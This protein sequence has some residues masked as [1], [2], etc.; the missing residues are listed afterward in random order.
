MAAVKVPA[1][2]HALGPASMIGL[3]LEELTSISSICST[4]TSV[5]RGNGPTTCGA[6][7]MGSR[8]L[9]RVVELAEAGAGPVA[10]VV[11]AGAVGGVA[12]ARQFPYVAGAED[13]ALV[14]LL[15]G[16]GSRRSAPGSRW[17]TW[18]AI[19]VHS[20][21]T[22]AS[23]RGVVRGQHREA[24]HEGRAVDQREALLGLQHDRGQTRLGGSASAAGTALA[25]RGGRRPRRDSIRAT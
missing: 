4:H 2:Q 10:V 14:R 20:S 17:R 9:D 1:V 23:S 18:L 7:Q 8:V 22:N 15:L 21:A 16:T 11:A 5:S 25:A 24:G 3:S 19:A 12:G 6:Q 13:D